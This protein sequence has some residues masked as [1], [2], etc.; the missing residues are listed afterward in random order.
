MYG[1]RLFR[2][3]SGRPLCYARTG[4]TG[5]IPSRRR[6]CRRRAEFMG[7]Y[8]V[9]AG[10][11]QRA[12]RAVGAEGAGVLG[13]HWRRAGFLRSASEPRSPGTS[14]NY[15]GS[16]LAIPMISSASRM[17][18]LRSNRRATHLLC[19]FILS[20]PMPSAPKIILPLIS[21]PFQ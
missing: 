12:S 14:H 16:T 6:R 10:S 8:G 13:F 11:R 2:F 4:K 9:R 18:S 7:T 3:G 15:P 20:P 17:R 19:T 5:G 1:W 21:F